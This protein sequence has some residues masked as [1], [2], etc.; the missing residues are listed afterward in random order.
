MK[1][2]VYPI[3]T[4]K[5]WCL[6]APPI[7]FDRASKAAAVRALHEHGYRIMW[8]G[9]LFDTTTKTDL[10]L[11][12]SLYGVPAVREREREIG[13]ALPDYAEIATYYVSVHP[14]DQDRT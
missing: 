2:I 11:R 14:R 7:P 9:G 1:A 5:D 6:S 10:E 8:S 3:I 12:T 4:G 13:Y